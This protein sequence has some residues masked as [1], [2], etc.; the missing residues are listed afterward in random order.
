MAVGNY[1]SG[2]DRSEQKVLPSL[3]T[4]PL[5]AL[6]QRS[7]GGSAAVTAAKLPQHAAM[8]ATKTLVATAIAGAQTAINNQLKAMAAPVMEMVTMTATTMNENKDN[9]GGSLVAARQQW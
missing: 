3:S 1:S 4:Y 6:R 9:G 5:E 2:G 7:G 8:V